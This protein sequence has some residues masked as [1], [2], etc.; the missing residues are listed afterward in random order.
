[1]SEGVESVKKLLKNAKFAHLATSDPE[2]NQPN[3]SLMDYVYL[4][5][6]ELFPSQNLK[7]A[8]SKECPKDLQSSFIVFAV[9]NTA[10]NFHNIQKNPKVSILIH[11]WVTAKLNSKEKG[12]HH[13]SSLLKMLHSLNHSEL[14]TIS[15]TLSGDAIIIDSSNEAMTK[16]YKQK[17][18]ND[19]QESKVFIEGKDKVIILIRIH[20]YKVVDAENNTK[21]Y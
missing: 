11:D 16:F 13:H 6:D 15:V 8:G 9:D 12:D 1:M 20:H 19:Y 3:V 18:L 10:T 4:N 7:A 5:K 2:T 17:L 14:S 21:A